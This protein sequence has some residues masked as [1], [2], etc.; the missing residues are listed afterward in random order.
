VTLPVA[1]T[2]RVFIPAGHPVRRAAVALA[3]IAVLLVIAWAGGLITPRLQTMGGGGSYDY[4]TGDGAQMVRLHNPAV[5]PLEIERVEIVGDGVRTGGAELAGVP[6]EKHPTL[7][8]NQAQDLNIAFEVV[9][10]PD[11][12]TASKWK[13]SVTARTPLG[14]TRTVSIPVGFAVSPPLC[15]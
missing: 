13:L 10:C 2:E 11:A 14:L 7:G 4:A 1:E 9:G 3:S 12:S 8:P 15:R 5:L 6:L